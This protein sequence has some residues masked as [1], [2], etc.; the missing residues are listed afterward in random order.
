MQPLKRKGQDRLGQNRGLRLVKWRNEDN[1]ECKG[2]QAAH[3]QAIEET[4]REAS[5]DPVAKVRGASKE[6][7]RRKQSAVNQ[8][9]LAT[10]F[11][12]SDDSDKEKGT[13]AKRESSEKT[14]VKKGLFDKAG[15]PKEEQE[16]Q[17]KAKTPK[18]SSRSNSP[19]PDRRKDRPNS[20]VDL[21]SS[22]S[23]Q[24]KK[25]GQKPHQQDTKNGVP[26]AG[27]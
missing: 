21:S 20:K 8:N 14:K 7:E 25:E 10:K 17:T 1:Y 3:R 27:N 12:D 15:K 2:T 5:L 9:R 11:G 13:A 16:S 24:G 22:D 26:Q 19:S 18:G 23:S 4:R 6:A